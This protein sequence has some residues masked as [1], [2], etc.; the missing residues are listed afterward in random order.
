MED[1]RTPG[2]K[3]SGEDLKL[4]TTLLPILTLILFPPKAGSSKATGHTH[5]LSVK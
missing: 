1:C 3:S 2:P 4:P 5:R